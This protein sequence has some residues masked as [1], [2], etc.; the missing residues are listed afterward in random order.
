M[1]GET[2]VPITKIFF[3]ADEAALKMACG[4]KGSSGLRPC[5]RCDC[6]SKERESLAHRLGKASIS[7]SDF[8]QFTIVDDNEVRE[9]LAHLQWIRNKKSRKDLDD[10]QKLLGWTL[11]D[12]CCFLDE[13]ISRH[14]Q[15]SQCHY[16]AMHC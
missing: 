11:N 9:I 14:L 3:V 6:F 10:A 2:I 8:S 15:L 5:L 7:C 4:T 1:V 13:N 12:H 16:D